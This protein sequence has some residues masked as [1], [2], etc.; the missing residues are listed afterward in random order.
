MRALRRS[1]TPLQ[2]K[3][4]AERLARQLRKHPLFLCSRRL[5][6]YLPADGEIDPRPLLKAALKAGKTCYLPVLHPTSHNR[7]WFVRYRPGC[8]MTRNHY[9]IDEP[10]RHLNPRTPAWTLDLVLMPLVAFDAEGGRLGMGGG[11]Y[12]RTF[13]F[14]RNPRQLKGPL[15]LGLAHDLQRV[16]RLELASWDIPLKGVATDRHLYLSGFDPLRLP[17][18]SGY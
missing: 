9:G 8:P 3:Q 14:I 16:E 12:D 17:P 7:L 10:H 11:Y 2:Q 6:F 18:Q 1:L 5:A 4:A 15:L 13:A